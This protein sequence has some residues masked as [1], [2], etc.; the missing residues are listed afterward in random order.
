MFHRLSCS[1]AL[2]LGAGCTTVQTLG[3]TIKTKTDQNAQASYAGGKAVF[4]VTRDGVTVE[5]SFEDTGSDIQADI[6][7][8]NSSDQP[9][10]V[11]PS[12]FVFEITSPKVKVLAVEKPEKVAE[13]WLTSLRMDRT[14]I[15]AHLVVHSTAPDPRELQAREQAQAVLGGALRKGPLAPHTGRSGRVY[16]ERQKKK[17]ESVLRVPIEKDTFEFA[18]KWVNDRVAAPMMAAQQQ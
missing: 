3:E 1:I 18:V 13:R 12:S 4:T 8:V 10:D 7:I 9:V 5:A 11:D 16:F 6:R 15:G 17:V 2:L 14:G